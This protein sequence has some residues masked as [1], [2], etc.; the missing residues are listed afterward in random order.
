MSVADDKDGKASPRVRREQFSDRNKTDVIA[1]HWGGAKLLQDR[2]KTDV[3]GE[4]AGLPQRI[5]DILCAMCFLV[6]F[7]V[8]ALAAVKARRFGYPPFPDYV[9]MKK[10]RHAIAHDGAIFPSDESLAD[11]DAVEKQLKAWKFIR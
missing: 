3:E 8:I 5:R 1:G 9:R 4:F 10:R 11:I 2:Y 7:D 6:A